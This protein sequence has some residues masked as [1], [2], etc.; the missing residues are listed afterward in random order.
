MMGRTRRLGVLRALDD[1]GCNNRAVSP[2]SRG[3]PP[4]RGGRRQP[5][6]RSPRNAGRPPGQLPGA[7]RYSAS[8]A[9]DAAGWWFDEPDPADRRSWAVPAGHGVYSGIDLELLDPD[10]ETDRMVLTEALHGELDDALHSGDEVTASGEPPSPRLHIAMHQVA[11]NQL[12]ADD[13]PETWQTVQRLISLGY[14]WHTIM[15]MIAAVIAKDVD[16]VLA[17]QRFDRAGYVRRLGEL[18]GDRPRSG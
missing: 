17:G 12:L 6:R 8:R 5:A 15:H 2:R 11:A 3:R 7:Q 18:P 10:S 16:R 1:D 4:G 9:G 14:D 13:P